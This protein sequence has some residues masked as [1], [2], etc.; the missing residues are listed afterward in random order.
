MN[1]LHV[2]GQRVPRI[3]GREIVT[4]EAQYT[5]DITFPGMLTGRILRSP[6]PH[7]YIRSIETQKAEALK[8]VLAV[9][10]ADVPSS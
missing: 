5:V 10:T 8:G 2:I 9:I 4:G 6:F 3:D 1:K 7:A